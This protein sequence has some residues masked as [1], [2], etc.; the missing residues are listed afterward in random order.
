M[1]RGFAWKMRHVRAR[2]TARPIS[3]PANPDLLPACAGPSLQKGKERI[4]KK[5]EKE[6]RMPLVRPRIPACIARL[7]GCSVHEIRDQI[8]PFG[9]LMTR[10]L[11]DF[12]AT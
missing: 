4:R 12:G 1:A 3:R 11:L 9:A 10:R 2:S 5:K 8:S 7:T 6:K